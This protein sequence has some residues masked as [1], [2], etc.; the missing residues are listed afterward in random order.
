MNGILV[1]SVSKVLWNCVEVAKVSG[2]PGWELASDR[3]LINPK[4]VISDDEMK[5]YD[6]RY[7]DYKH[8]IS[9]IRVGKSCNIEDNVGVIREETRDHFIVEFESSPK[10]GDLVYIGDGE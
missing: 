8:A 4:I 10:Y 1:G 5:Q 6:K 3:R 9:L 7:E 2:R